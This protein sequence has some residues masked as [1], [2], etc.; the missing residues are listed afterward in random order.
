MG[1]ETNLSSEKRGRTKVP[2][3]QLTFF[4]NENVRTLEVAVKNARLVDSG[5]R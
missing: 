4:A 5:Q 3:S 1:R 2:D